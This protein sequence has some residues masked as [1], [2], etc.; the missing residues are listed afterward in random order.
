MK[1]K[2]PSGENE[3]TVDKLTEKLAEE[4]ISEETYQKA[5]EKLEGES[6]GEKK[7]RVILYAQPWGIEN[8]RKKRSSTEVA[9]A[10]IGLKFCS[11]ISS[12]ACWRQ[13]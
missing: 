2:E 7:E 5:I 13:K 3:T 10:L 12:A 8:G 9:T 11:S 6:K 1:K 4:E